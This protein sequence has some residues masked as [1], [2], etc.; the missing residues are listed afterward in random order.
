MVYPFGDWLEEKLYYTKN[1]TKDE[2]SCL[3]Y[4][5]I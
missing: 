1:H 3:A 5:V 2:N 4:N